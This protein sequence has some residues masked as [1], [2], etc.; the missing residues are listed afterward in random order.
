MPLLTIAVADVPEEDAGLASGI[1][2][3][4]MQIAAALGLAIL[5]AAGVA[6][7]AWV[8]AARGLRAPRPTVG[9][10]MV[11]SI[12]GN[13]GYLGLPV[14]FAVLGSGALGNAIA[15]DA[16]LSVATLLIGGAAIGAALG[17]HARLGADVPRYRLDDV[18]LGPA[19]ADA[20]I[21]E[22]LATYKLNATR[23]DDVEATTAR[24][25]ADGRIVGWFQGRMEFGPRALGARSIL[26]DPRRAEMKDRVNESVKFREGWRPFA[27]SCLAEDA[28]EWFERCDDAPFMIL[29]FTVRPEK[30]ALI[31]AV[32]HADGTARVQTVRRDV[33]P[34]YWRVI[35][36][37]AAL[38]GVP[39]VMNTSFNLRGEPIVCTPKDAIRTFYSSGLDFLVIGDHVLA[40]DAAWR[41]E[42]RTERRARVAAA[43]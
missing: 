7:L 24:L 39:V 27:P 21:A 14:A 17:A 26:A 31:P 19:F 15:Y 20:Q 33:N 38:T 32:T 40:K 30:R 42:G 37:F 43:R 22:T 5:V 41:P 13:T 16:I 1:V 29:T 35:R 4:S 18:Y 25:L 6:A 2:N 12:Q 11:S 36:E 8:I 28:P 3:V 10:V 9:S 23:V 34:R